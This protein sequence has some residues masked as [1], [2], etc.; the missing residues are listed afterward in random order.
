[1]IVNIIKSIKSDNEIEF[2]LGDDIHFILCRNDKEYICYGVIADI[3][4]AG[5][6]NQ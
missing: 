3:D 5:F 1:M 4:S 2:H 6:F